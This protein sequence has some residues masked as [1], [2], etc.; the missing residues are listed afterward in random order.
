[1][2]KK[3]GI[4]KVVGVGLVKSGRWLKVYTVDGNGVRRAVHFPVDE[5]FGGLNALY[6]T[7]KFEEWFNEAVSDK[8]YW[9]Y[10]RN[11]HYYG[12]ENESGFIDDGGEEISTR[13]FDRRKM[14]VEISEKDWMNIIRCDGDKH[15]I[16]NGTYFSDETEEEQAIITEQIMNREDEVLEEVVA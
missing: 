4:R 16:E 8:Y 5:R 9:Q 2:S 11:E 14:F 10:F 13:C 15:N 6:A 12:F 7:W 1:M 3:N